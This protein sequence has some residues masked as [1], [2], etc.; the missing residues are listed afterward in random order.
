M[1]KRLTYDRAL[2]KPVCT[3]TKDLE[4]AE[5]QAHLD[6]FLRNGGTI[7]RV[8]PSATAINISSPCRTQDDA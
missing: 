8:P 3:R 7:Q 4:R 6:E 1:L 2:D 5:L